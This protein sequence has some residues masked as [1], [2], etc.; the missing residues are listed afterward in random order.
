MYD[1]FIVNET[2][3]K[4][5]SAE[6]IVTSF[7]LGG[8][9]SA[10]DDKEYYDRQISFYQEKS[11]Q[12]NEIIEILNKVS[13]I[14]KEKP[15]NHF[16]VNKDSTDYSRVDYYPAEKRSNMSRMTNSKLYSLTVR[17]KN[18]NPDAMRDEITLKQPLTEAEAYR[19]CLE[20]LVCD[21]SPA[22]FVY[23]VERGKI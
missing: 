23:D 12:S 6:D 13:F 11:S 15:I 21:A 8:L 10:I 19:L 17:A 9:Q 3:K 5:M 16:K 20:F 7:N 1:F 18:P 22:E 14:Y 2:E 4:P